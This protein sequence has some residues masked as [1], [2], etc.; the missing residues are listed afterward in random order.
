MRRLSSS[1]FRIGV[2]Q[3]I[4]DYWG[5]LMID[6]FASMVSV[7]LPRFFT[8]GDA[9]GAEAYDMLE[10]GTFLSHMLSLIQLFF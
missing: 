4:V 1:R 9:V 3:Q 10:H 5:V 8:W 7:L 2:F 6:L